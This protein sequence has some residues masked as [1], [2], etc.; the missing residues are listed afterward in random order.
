[1]NVL[2]DQIVKVLNV[3]LPN[4]LVQGIYVGISVTL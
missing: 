1:M 2:F 3:L 4:T